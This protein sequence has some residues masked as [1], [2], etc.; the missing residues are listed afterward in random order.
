MRKEINKRENKIELYEIRGW[1]TVKDEIKRLRKTIRHSLND[2]AE[3][4][5]TNDTN[6]KNYAKKKKKKRTSMKKRQK[7]EIRI[8]NE[9][10][11]KVK[12]PSQKYHW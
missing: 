8:L 6:K 10:Q 4:I 5:Y 3:W 2:E 11:Y 7:K 9:L 1:L 12:F